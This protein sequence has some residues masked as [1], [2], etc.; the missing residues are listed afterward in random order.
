MWHLEG[1]YEG[2]RRLGLSRSAIYRRINSFRTRF[3][4]HPDVYKFPGV[5]LDELD[6][7]IALNSGQAGIPY[8]ERECADSTVVSGGY[9]D[10]EDYGDAIVYTG[11]GGNDPATKRQVADQQFAR[12]NLAL[13]RNADDALPVRV[14]RGAGGD[15]SYSPAAGYRYDGLFSV[16]RYW[17]EVGRSGY[18]VWRY[19][20]LQVADPVLTEEDS[21]PES[22][23]DGPVPRVLSTVQGLVRITAVS[24]RVKELHD[25]RCQLCGVQLRTPSGVYVEGAHI[26]PLGRPHNG[27]DKEGNILCLCPNHHVLFDTGALH[28][29]DDLSV[30]ES[31]SGEPVWRASGGRGHLIDVTSLRYHRE[32]LAPVP[33]PDYPGSSLVD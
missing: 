30:V 14:V 16:E 12:G 15:P 27:A 26:R 1:G 7:L 5:T 2:L 11:H 33:H 10:D 32:H 21:E 20:L 22:G 3:G 13:A 23:S 24:R 6:L 17:H 31:A 19:R 8:S 28:V 25:Y 29:V 9:E 4:E 18:T